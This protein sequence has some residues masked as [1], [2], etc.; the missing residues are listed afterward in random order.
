MCVGGFKRASLR[1]TEAS[2]GFGVS[3]RVWSGVD[4]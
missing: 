1:G 4:E 3:L 2:G